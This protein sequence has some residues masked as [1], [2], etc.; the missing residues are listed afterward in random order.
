VKIAITWRNAA[1][2]QIVREFDAEVAIDQV[3]RG[4]AE[5]V[6]P[7]DDLLQRARGQAANLSD[8]ARG[9][10]A[11]ATAGLNFLRGPTTRLEKVKALCHG[12]KGR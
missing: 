2:E 4:Y 9:D 8:S 11:A 10:A 1:G 7:A 12:M 3:A 6:S 5:F